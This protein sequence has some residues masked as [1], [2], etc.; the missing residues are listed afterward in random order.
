MAS[1]VRLS[2]GPDRSAQIAFAG[3]VLAGGVNAIAIRQM[4]LEL[5]PLWGS[6]GRFIVAGLILAALAILLHRS[7]PRGR[8]LGG[9]M[10]YGAVGFAASFGPISSGM[11]FVPGATGS[12]L[13]AITPLFTFGLAIAQ[14]QERF[15]A[16]GLIGALVALAGI[17]IVFAD[18]ASAAIPISSLV[19]VLV[20]S[21]AIAESAIILKAVPRSDPFATNAVAMLTG[22]ALLLIASFVLGESHPLPTRAPTWIALGYLVVFGSVVLFSLFVFVLQRW[23]ASAVS[24]A[25][26]LFPFVGVTVATLLTGESFDPAFFV[27]GAVMLIGVYVGAFRTRPQR[28]SATSAPECL[29]IDACADAA[30]PAPAGARA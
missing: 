10:L 12:V 4:V 8:S 5:P 27:G 19:L 20:G 30:A 29:P 3:A 24:Y 18:Q 1:P 28:S 25:T 22:G 17:A 11:R 14:R 26:L 2:F 13:I 15:R 6:A 7:F 16:Q 9:A 21:V 23:T